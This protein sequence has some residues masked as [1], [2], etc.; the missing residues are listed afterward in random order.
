M[1]EYSGFTTV[2]SNI[3]NKNNNIGIYIY[4][5]VYGNV[6]YNVLWRNVGYGVYLSASS[7]NSRVHHNNFVANNLGGTSQACDDGASN[8]WYDT[9]ALEGNYWSDWSGTGSY[10]I[11]GSAGAIDLYPFDKPTVFLGAPVITTIIHSPSTPT[12]L[13]TI[14]ITA[15][16][17]SPYG[18]QSVALHYRVN[19][20]TW[21]EVSMILIS[22]DLYSVTIGSFADSDTIEYY[23][24]AVDNSIDNN[25]STED[26]GGLYYTIIVGSSDVTGPSITGVIYSPSTPTELDTICINAT[27]TDDS[28]IYTVTLHY[29]VNGGIWTEVSMTLVSGDLYS[30]TI[31]SF[32]VNDIIEYYVTAVDNSFNHN[33][34]TEDNSGLYYLFTVLAVIPEFQTFSLLLPAMS[35][36]FFVFGLAVLQRRKK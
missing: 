21:T 36:L 33:E 23:V 27:V 6:T 25:E 34:S 5:S 12:E 35:I 19:S 30:V 28:G 8:Y 9:L 32:T 2:V 22:G 10:A 1:I 20:G 14:S 26:N 29:R 24:S 3:C 16:V 11:D 13:D 31:G 17:T 18:V 7:D 4:E 15:I